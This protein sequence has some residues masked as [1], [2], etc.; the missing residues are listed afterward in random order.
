[1][2]VVEISHPREGK[3]GF[4]IK[5]DEMAFH[6]E[7]GKWFEDESEWFWGETPATPPKRDDRVLVPKN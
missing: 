4:E 3:S 7:W 5:G 2:G 6:G 1:M